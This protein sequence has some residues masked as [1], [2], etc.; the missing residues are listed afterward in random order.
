MKKPKPT[1][2]RKSKKVPAGGA[3]AAPSPPPPKAIPAAD[4]LSPEYVL[5][6]RREAEAD[7]LAAELE[8]QDN[9]P[10]P[11]RAADGTFVAGQSGNPAGRPVGSKNYVT[12]QRLAMEAALRDYMHTPTRRARLMKLIDRV[13]EI[14]LTG[15][16]KNAINA[17]KIMF[18]RVLSG[19]KQEDDA[20]GKT[21]PRVVV[22][23]ENMTQQPAKVAVITEGQFTEVLEMNERG[24]MTDDENAKGVGT[25]PLSEDQGSFLKSNSLSDNNDSTAQKGAQTGTDTP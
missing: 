4:A 19:A 6:L 12:E 11:V 10:V 5:G 7:V 1:Q 25:Q 3:D 21:P 9:L 20:G 2:P 14:G 24:Q 18:D 8:R 17:A 15:E 16:D 23:I 22:V 13:L